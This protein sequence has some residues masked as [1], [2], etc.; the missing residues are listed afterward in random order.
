MPVG[1]IRA[2][3]HLPICTTAHSAAQS[4]LCQS[5]AKPEKDFHMEFKSVKVNE[6]YG[7]KISYYLHLSCSFISLLL[8]GKS[9]RMPLTYH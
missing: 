8:D 4:V 1:A 2:S 7:L 6:K 5:R 3:P 9:L